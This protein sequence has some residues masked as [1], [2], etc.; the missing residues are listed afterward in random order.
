[1]E[2]A[3]T[4][5]R[6]WAITLD[7][8]S[9]LFVLAC[10]AYAVVRSLQKSED[11]G[12]L[13]FRWCLSA[14][15]I[16]L[17][18]VTM[19]ALPYGYRPLAGIVFGIPLS[20]IWAP[21][22]GAMVA[23]PLTSMFDGGSTQ[24]EPAPMYSVAQARRRKGL[25]NEAAAEVVRQLEQ[26]P[27]DL[28]GTLLLAAIQAEDMKDV[29]A[30][31]ATI[32]EFLRQPKL[33]PQAAAAALGNL[34][35][36]QLRHGGGADAA[37]A[38]FERICQMFPDTAYAHAAEQRI[39]HLEAADKTRQQREQVRYT[40]PTGEKDIGL[41]RG[42][43]PEA[44]PADPHA[45]AEEWV[46]Q[47]QRHPLDTETRENLALLYAEEFQRVDLA[48]EQLE[49]L[50]ALRAEPPKRIARWL[51]LLATVQARFGNNL[52]AAESAL[53]RIQERFPKSSMAAEAT[54][55]LASLNQEARAHQPMVAKTMGAYE[56]E[57]GLKQTQAGV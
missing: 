26:F 11:P 41:R 3:G 56:K 23:S 30:A 25:Y 9:L 37:R 5:Q 7:V 36:W 39:A 55:R 33:P 1:M 38:S 14:G 19:K 10:L 34:A 32:E 8:L 50:I 49:E 44:A 35:D 48:A 17:G 52:N 6:F 51:N 20:I 24:V 4:I 13:I 45:Q 47:L 12:R 40:V 43:L 28:T 22:I 42:A 2:P 18:L 46:A 15:L 21:S 31:E 29:P 16:A 27:G 54:T 53:R 57:I